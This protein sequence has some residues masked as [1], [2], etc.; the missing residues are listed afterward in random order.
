[1]TIN[2][3]PDKKQITAGNTYNEVLSC[4]CSMEV[5]IQ[6]SLKSPAASDATDIC[7]AFAKCSRGFYLRLG[8]EL[9]IDDLIKR[10]CRALFGRE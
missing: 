7:K 8:K 9:N 1:M 6:A 5:K 10:E 3:D 4:G 2:I